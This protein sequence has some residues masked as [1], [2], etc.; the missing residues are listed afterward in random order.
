[1][2]DPE[3]YEQTEEKNEQTELKDQLTATPEAITSYYAKRWYDMGFLFAVNYIYAILPDTNAGI[4]FNKGIFKDT[5]NRR[6][7]LPDG[8]GIVDD[9]F[10][11]KHPFK[12]TGP[13]SYPNGQCPGDIPGT[14]IPCTADGIK[15]FP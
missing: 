13:S 1:M 2:N 5:L 14:C 12:E 6:F 8:T 4:E 11:E 3:K 9:K 10:F 15:P 7:H